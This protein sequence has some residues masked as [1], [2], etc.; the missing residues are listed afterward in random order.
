MST[1]FWKEVMRSMA[2]QGRW[3]ELRNSFSQDYYTVRE[4]RDVLADK[5]LQDSNKNSLENSPYIKE[6]AQGAQVRLVEHV[7]EHLTTIGDGAAKN[8]R[9]LTTEE[10]E[11]VKQLVYEGMSHKAARAEVLGVGSG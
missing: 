5:G 10:A 6:G 1:A 3:N 11:Q 7:H 4:A 8:G 9:R 2:S